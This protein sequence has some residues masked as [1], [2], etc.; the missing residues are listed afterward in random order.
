[1]T[2]VSLPEH[3]SQ[4]TDLPGLNQQVRSGAARLNWSQ[5]REVTRDDLRAL[6]SGMQLTDAGLGTETMSSPVSMQVL[7][8]LYSLPDEEGG[9]ALPDGNGVGSLSA[10]NETPGESVGPLSALRPTPVALRRSLQVMVVRDLMGPAGGPEEEVPEDR[11]TDRYILG[12]L[13]PNW[14]VPPPRD[15]DDEVKV[16]GADAADE[17][18]PEEDVLDP[19]SMFPSSLGLSFLVEPETE[20][21]RVHVRY[22]RYERRGSENPDVHERVWKRIPLEDTV[23]LE[24][25]EI[26]SSPDAPPVALCKEDGRDVQLVRRVRPTEGQGSFV[27]LFLV[28]AQPV[29]QS[30]K[31]AAWIFQPE[32]EVTGVDGSMPF[33]C[34]DLR[35][36]PVAMDNATLEEERS[37]AMLYRRYR[38][39]AVGHGVSVEAEVVADEPHRAR[40]LRTRTVPQYEVPS[41]EMP[42]EDEIPGLSAIDLDMK[43]LSQMDRSALTDNLQV[44][45]ATY[46]AWIAG[47]WE[48]LEDPYSDLQAYRDAGGAALEGCEDAHRRILAGIA[49]LGE[50]DDALEAFRFAN[51]AMWLQRIHSVYALERRSRGPRPLEEIDD[52]ANRSWRLFQIAFILLNLP[53]ITQLDHTDRSPSPEAAADLLW[54]PT[55]GGKTEAYLGLTAYTLAIRRLQSVVEGRDGQYGVAVLMR[56]TLRLLTL[57][58]FQRAATLIC[59]CE[60]IRR[61]SRFEG[62][63]RWGDEPFRLGLWVGNRTTPNT[64]DQAHEAIAEY[65][66]G[67]GSGSGSATPAQL[68][69]CPWCGT[70]IDPGLDI[71]VEKG[72]R[73]RGRVFMYCGDPQGECPFS[74]RQS[75]VWD[76][77]GLPLCV[78][79]EE[80]YHRLPALLISTVD[81]FAQMPWKGETEML[82]GQVDGYCSRHGFHCPSMDPEADHRAYGDLPATRFRTNGPLRPPD[83]IIQDEL[84]LISGPLGS[85]VGI[86]E[87]A[88]DALSTWDVAGRPV[89]P[90]VIASTATVRR[91]SEQVRSLFLRS[92]RVFPPHGTDI[93]DDFFARRREPSD[94]KPGRLYVGIYAPGRRMKAVLIRVYV[95][96]L[97]AAARL[98]NDH[99]ALADPWMTLVG[100][101]SSMREL[102]GMRRLVEDDIRSRLRRTEEHGLANRYFRVIEEL[103]SRK[104]SSEIPIVLEQLERQFEDTEMDELAKS[105]GRKSRTPYRSSPIDVLLATNMLSVGVD[106]QRLGLMLVAGQPKNTAEYIQATSRVG[107][108]KNGPGLVCTV[109][110]WTRPRDLSHYESFEHFHATVYQQVEPLSVTPFA[111]RA[112]DRALT[113]VLTSLIRLQGTRLNDNLAAGKVTREDSYVRA[114]INDIVQRFAAVSEED[115]SAGQVLTELQERLTAWI[116]EAG[117]REGGRRLG[118]KSSPDGLTV[119]LLRRPTEETWSKLTCLESLREVEPEINLIL[120]E[121]DLD[122][123][124]P[125]LVMGTWRDANE[126]PEEEVEV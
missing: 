53:G 105:G 44:L 65:K 19:G 25:R 63:D 29:P 82:F 113:G 3:L 27:T 73:G 46:K 36:E 16:V 41:T 47:Q 109:Y 48:A 17:G 88:V 115:G 42:T 110:N 106:V 56:Y 81:K 116:R 67:K 122:R 62:D 10:D 6:L 87:T 21:L 4:L 90:K 64:I 102:G 7:E 97:A 28:N 39:F 107:R 119:G 20:V 2:V 43:T 26:A 76:G 13:A 22:A 108:S 85:L 104:P 38:D 50:D 114:A 55:G 57:Q 78:V 91:A 95:A 23:S 72:P 18:T 58:Q 5:V 74:K 99:R 83:L 80:I 1:M 32:L 54:F 51:H 98:Y 79:D 93:D 121:R 45:A 100:Y 30:N 12:V 31:D 70:R 15:A 33:L 118:Y 35:R 9:A 96:Y 77:E 103:T 24:L 61:L 117:R 126:R 101:F 71:V 75:E 59:A 123:E 89:R 37:M 84:H 60:Q 11:V 14:E 40:L 111:P 69:H 49:L 68:T 34:R 52:A 8:V 112:R 125:P 66:N 124:V 92:V 94:E 120:D 86:Y